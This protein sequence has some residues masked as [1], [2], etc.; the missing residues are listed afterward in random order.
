MPALI[1]PTPLR[2]QTSLDDMMTE[3]LHPPQPPAPM[4]IQPP[5]RFIPLSFR[6]DARGPRPRSASP[7]L[8]AKLPPLRPY[9]VP[10]AEPPFITRD[11]GCCRPSSRIG[12]P[13]PRAPAL[14]PSQFPPVQPRGPPVTAANIGCQLHLDEPRRDFLDGVHQL[15]GQRPSATWDGWI[16]S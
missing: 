1:V 2:P 8:P 7:T 14:V 4:Q 16:H 3:L 6:P 15:R 9:T 5:P 13:P 11:L 12:R 10:L